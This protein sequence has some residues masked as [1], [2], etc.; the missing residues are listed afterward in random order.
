MINTI[1]VRIERAARTWFSKMT[2]PSVAAYSP[3]DCGDFIRRQNEPMP[4]SVLAGSIIDRFEEIVSRHSARPAVS[5]A[6]CDL[7]YAELAR[8]VERIAAATAAAAQG[9]GPVAIVLP[10]GA[11][12]AAAALGALASGRGYVPL[13][14][15]EAMERNRF[16]AVQ[17][18]AAAVISIGELADRLREFFPQHL[19]VLM[20]DSLGETSKAKYP[21]SATGRPF[22]H[23]LYV[24]FDGRT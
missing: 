4:A 8:I 12:F 7:S 14:T 1:G 20:V 2:D 10:N 15:S 16:I 17:S 5:D 24:W 19:P 9:P 13:D 21:R 23:H 3:E 11:Y 6:R 18:G 22:M